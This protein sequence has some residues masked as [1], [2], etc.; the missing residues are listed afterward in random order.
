MNELM[1][2]VLQG[3]ASDEERALLDR[4]RNRS[5]ENEEEFD[6]LSALWVVTGEGRVDSALSDPPDAAELI[7]MAERPGSPAWDNGGLRRNQAVDGRRGDGPSAPR[8]G[9]GRLAAAAVVAGL[10]AAGAGV[11]ASG[12]LRGGERGPLAE[13]VIATGAGEMTTLSLADGSSI[14]IGPE[15]TLGLTD[16]S[17][18][19][20]VELEGRAFFGVQ[21]NA[22][23]RFSVV[24][25]YGE[26]VAFGTRFEVR[27]EGGE[28][29][30]LVVDGEV[31]VSL[32]D[33]PPALLRGGE[34]SLSSGEGPLRATKVADVLGHLEWMGNALVFQATPLAMAATEIERRYG[35]PIVIEDGELETVELTMTFTDR[36]MEEV[37]LV[38]CE[39]VGADCVFEGDEVRI[40]SSDEARVGA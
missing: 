1:L 37:L 27:S 7:A 31:E 21:A 26:A 30:V 16:G 22:S 4:W 32:H 5:R 17:G 38:I 20:V 40:R 33:G 29:K 3:R 6:A 9:R 11:M 36:A 2:K 13:G 23:R 15:T 8:R 12:L 39:V 10:I 28:F 34:M 24:T 19:Q 14:R 18:G 35:V 25:Q